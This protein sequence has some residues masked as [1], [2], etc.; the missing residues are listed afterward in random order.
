MYLY[1]LFISDEY[2]SA[3]CLSKAELDYHAII[4]ELSRLNL[5][6]VPRHISSMLNEEGGIRF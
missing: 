3:K 5:G 1:A 4:E 2:Y 6:R